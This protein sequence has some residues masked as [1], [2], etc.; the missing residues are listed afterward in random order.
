MFVVVFVGLFALSRLVAVPLVDTLLRGR[1]V[2]DHARK[3]LWLFISGVFIYID[4]PFR[5]G[6]WIEWG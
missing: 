4:K 6:D 1:G 3:P 2:D 5:T